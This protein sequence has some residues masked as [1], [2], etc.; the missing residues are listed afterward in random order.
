MET[1]RPEDALAALRAQL[2]G[3]APDADPERFGH[4]S[5]HLGAALLDLGESAEAERRLGDAVAV[6]PTD[7]H[8][9]E[10]A[11]AVNLLGAALRE[12]A[13]PAAAAACFTTAA[14]LFAAE[15]LVVEQAAALHNLGLCHRDL[16]EPRQ[17]Q[18]LLAEAAAL[19]EQAGAWAHACAAA[20]ELGAAV[21]DG[22]DA[23]AAVE[24]LE[25]AVG[26]GERC[27]ESHLVA[28]A[29]NVLGL[30]QLAAG[31]PGLAVDAFGSSAGAAPRSVRPAEHAMAKANLALAWEHAGDESRARLAARQ[32]LAIPQ[33][34]QAV[35][36]QASAVLERLGDDDGDLERVLGDEPPERRIALLREEL[37]WWAQADRDSRLRHCGGLVELVASAEDGA[38]LAEAWLDVLLELPPDDMDALIRATLQ[39]LSQRPG[40]TREA[41]HGSLARALPRFALPQWLRARQRFAAIAEEVGPRGGGMD[42]EVTEAPAWT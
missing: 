22:G 30:A 29:A 32:A 12:R 40:P 28:A 14:E 2:D 3:C 36:L 31:R 42:R 16:G 15:G 35:T 20:R 8:P 33:A 11:T 19:F 41:F 37:V 39:A 5:F 9:V 21:L 26:L 23:G 24:V 18:P 25:H 4:A 1:P 38:D 27:G 6:F 13:S 34:A 17:A 10:H 7:T